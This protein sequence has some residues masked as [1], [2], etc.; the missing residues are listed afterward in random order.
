[1]VVRIAQEFFQNSLKHASPSVLGASVVSEPSVVK[2]ELF[3]NGVGF[4]LEDLKA[5]EK[6]GIHNMQTRARSVGAKF[7]LRSSANE[8]TH[9][10]L[11]LQRD[12]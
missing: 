11:E 1:V 9:L 7:M 12:G 4:D 5:S 8:G 2:V 10:I 6:S 3:D